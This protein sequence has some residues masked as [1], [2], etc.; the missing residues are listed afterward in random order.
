V[1]STPSEYELELSVGDDVALA[2]FVLS[3]DAA[4][5]DAQRPETLDQW[6]DAIVAAGI[7]EVAPA[8]MSSHRRNRARKSIMSEDSLDPARFPMITAQMTSIDPVDDTNSAHSHR[9]WFDLTI[10]ETTVSVDWPASIR[11][12]DGRIEVETFGALHFTDFGMKPYSSFFG[13]I[14]YKDE[15]HVFV[16]IECRTSSEE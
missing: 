1:I 14:R 9:I 15:F 13:A 4:S 2:D 7:L 6:S 8:P 16:H 12:Q 3:I 10:R 11:R 5:I